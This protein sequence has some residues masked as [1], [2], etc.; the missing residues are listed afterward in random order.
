MRRLA[1][2]FL[3]APSRYQRLLTEALSFQQDTK[4]FVTDCA[5]AI[6]GS[7]LDGQ[8]SLVLDRPDPLQVI[9]PSSPFKLPSAFVKDP[10][11]PVGAHDAVFEGTLPLVLDPLHLVVRAKNLIDIIVVFVAHGSLAIVV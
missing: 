10:F 8:Q 9:F 5:Y 2:S 1:V 3:K 7:M 4:V 6:P 11:L